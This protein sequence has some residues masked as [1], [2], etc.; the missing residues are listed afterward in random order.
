[1]TRLLWSLACWIY[2]PLIAVPN[3]LTDQTDEHHFT[4]QGCFSGKIVQTP[5][6]GR[7][8]WEG[9]ICRSLYATTPV[10]SSSHGSLATGLY[11]HHH[12]VAESNIPFPDNGNTFATILNKK[13]HR[14]GFIGKWYLD[15]NGKP[16]WELNRCFGFE[17]N[18]YTFNQGHW[19]KFKIVGGNPRVDGKDNRDSPND[20]LDGADEKTISTD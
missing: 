9:A 15:G 4:T 11:P 17:D 3:L 5:N 13:G 19:K 2:L 16:L 18:R 6:I 8:T 10:C 7:I 20:G 14:T 12:Q 1:M